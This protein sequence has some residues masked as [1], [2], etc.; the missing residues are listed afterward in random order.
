[1]KIKRAVVVAFVLLILGVVGFRAKL[2][3]KP[4]FTSPPPQVLLFGCN[5]SPNGDSFIS[6]G[7]AGTSVTASTCSQALADALS[8]GFKIQ[9][10]VSGGGESLYSYNYTL[11]KGGE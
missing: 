4:A 3:A 1:M 11:I 2:H 10:V 6:Q 9:S 7:S 8:A 5:L